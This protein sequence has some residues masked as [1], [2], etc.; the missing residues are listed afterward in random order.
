ME[1]EVDVGGFSIAYT[2]R[3][4]GPPL[5]LVPGVTMSALRWVEAGYVEALAGSR[6][7]LAVDPLG[8]GRSSKTA[9]VDAYAR[10]RL[11]EHLVAVLDDASVEV[12]DVWG[13]S[14][15]SAM[16][17]LLAGAHPDRV[18]RLVVGGYPLF[19]RNTILESLGMLPDRSEVESRHQR[20]LDGDW[21]AYWE[22]FPLPLPDATKAQLS[23]RNDLASISAC[24]VA[25]HLD[26][27][28]WSAP[29]GVQTLAYWGEDEIFN[30]LNA[31][32]AT[33]Q[34]ISTA[35]VPGGHAEAFFPSGP[36]LAAVTAF[37]DTE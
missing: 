34:P 36:A 25:S 22:S 5:L 12:A 17:G 11:V 31:Q 20:C 6:R 13:Y 18:R 2:V 37:L 14:R 21:D 4:E 1:C 24:A 7:V 16:S 15:G 28:D 35:T 32:A 26:P 8:H 27:M 33:D 9:E 19:E 10:D 30:D 3:G 29:N 23:S